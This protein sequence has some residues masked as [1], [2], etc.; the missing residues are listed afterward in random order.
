MSSTPN[1][2]AE[3]A[4][5]QSLEFTRLVARSIDRVCLAGTSAVNPETVAALKP[6]HAVDVGTAS[7]ISSVIIGDGSMSWEELAVPLRYT[8][9]TQ[10]R[11]V[12]EQFASAGVLA[13]TDEGVTYTEA[14]RAASQAYVDTMPAAI[15]AL[16]Q[17]DAQRIPRLAELLMPVFDAASQSGSPFVDITKRVLYPTQ[18][19][20]AYDLWRSLV[21]VRRHRSDCHAAAWSAADYDEVTIRSLTAGSER[22]AIE[23]DTNAGHEPVWAALDEG[24]QVEALALL[25][26]LNGSGSPH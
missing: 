11:T 1:H 10:R 24:D 21:L 12:G 26:G 9:S 6:S 14:G 13:I 5:M 23:A 16:W 15:A 2:Q 7:L 8:P 22:E 18:T 19:N 20:A 3:G 4:L 17:I 25:A